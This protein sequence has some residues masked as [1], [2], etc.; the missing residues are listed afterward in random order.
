MCNLLFN[1]YLG[2]KLRASSNWKQLLL[3]VAWLQKESEPRIAL[4]NNNLYII[5]LLAASIKFNIRKHPG[6]G[7]KG[8]LVYPS[9]GTLM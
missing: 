3:K 6:K 4:P 2:L 7:V 1:N 9:L 5:I 8:I